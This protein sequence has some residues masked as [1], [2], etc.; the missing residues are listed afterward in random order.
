[1]KYR[2]KKEI[3][4]M[5]KYINGKRVHARIHMYIIQ[6][7]FVIHTADK[8]KKSSASFFL[9]Q[10]VGIPPPKSDQKVFKFI[11][12]FGGYKPSKNM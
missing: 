6:T 9:Y 8:W 4:K 12:F 2:L 3:A 7:I 11:F 5:A 1:M 10:M